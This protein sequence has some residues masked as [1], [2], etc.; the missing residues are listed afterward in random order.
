MLNRLDG[1]VRWQRA[2]DAPLAGAPLVHDGWVA[3][4]LRD[5]H[6]EL[7][8][9]GTGSTLHSI[10]YE[11]ILSFAPTWAFGRLYVVDSERKLHA[12]GT[13]P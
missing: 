5:G 7:L 1:S 9:A 3:A 13:G 6:L 2:L 10:D 8:E 11:S 12:L 4:A